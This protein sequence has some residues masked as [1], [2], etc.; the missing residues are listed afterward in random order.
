MS[1]EFVTAFPSLKLCNELISK[2]AKI[3]VLLVLKVS[4]FFVRNIL[5]INPGNLERSSPL[6]VLVPSFK[7]AIEVNL[8]SKIAFSELWP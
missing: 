3:L 6:M 2:L 7:V 5:D 1:L 4:E 8:L